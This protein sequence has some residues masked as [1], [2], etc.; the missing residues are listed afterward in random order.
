ME[1]R[2]NRVRI[3]RS[4]PVMCNLKGRTGMGQVFTFAT[5]WWWEYHASENVT[6]YLSMLSLLLSE[7]EMQPSNTGNEDKAI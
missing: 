2:I 1:L 4:R 3:K 6:P 7:Q 5:V